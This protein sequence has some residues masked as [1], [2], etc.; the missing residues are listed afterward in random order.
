M[1]L[2][3]E[4]RRRRMLA[5][6]RRSFPVSA[7]APVHPQLRSEE[8]RGLQTA[9]VAIGNH[10][11]THPCL[12]RCSEEQMREE[13]ARAHERISSMTGS[14]PVAFAY[15]NGDWDARAEPMLAELGYRVAFLFDHA[16]TS[17]K[18]DPLRMSRVRT[19]ST[20]SLERLSLIVSGLHPTLH[21]LRS[22][23][24]GRPA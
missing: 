3:P 23:F 1:K 17:P 15:P 4:E 19:D 14:E 11:V 24:A 22:R 9:G 7:P 20:V 16:L 5:E 18:Q 21:R 2:V 8:L 13:I 12:P 10:T 6:L